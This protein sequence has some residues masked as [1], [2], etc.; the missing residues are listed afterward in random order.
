MEARVKG[1]KLYLTAVTVLVCTVLQWSR[2]L[3]FLINT[4]DHN[5]LKFNI[6][7]G[8]YVTQPDSAQKQN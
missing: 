7:R 8:K 3:P 4:L 2:T 5:S 6:L 1:H